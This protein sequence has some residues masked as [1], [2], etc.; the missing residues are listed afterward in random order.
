MTRSEYEYFKR[1]L[2]VELV[3]LQ[4]WVKS[5]GKHPASASGGRDRHVRPFLVQPGRRGARHG[6]LHR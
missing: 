2:Q 5:V 3:K 4:N 6:V 1:P